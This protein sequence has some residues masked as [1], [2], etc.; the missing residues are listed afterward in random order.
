MRDGRIELEPSAP[1]GECPLM[2]DVALLFDAL[3][4]WFA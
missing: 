1:H 4:Q 2:V 3:G